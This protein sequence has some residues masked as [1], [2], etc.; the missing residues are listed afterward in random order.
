MNHLYNNKGD[1]NTPREKNLI[2]RH[3]TGKATEKEEKEL[4]D[5]IEEREENK[6]FFLQTKS[7]WQTTGSAKIDF[8]PDKEWKKIHKR[9]NKSEPSFPRSFWIRF[10]KTA[11]VFIFAFTIGWILKTHLTQNTGRTWLQVQVPAGQITKVVLSDG[12]KVW[13]DS[14][15]TFRYPSDFSQNGRNVIL[16]GQAYFEVAENRNSP[17]T[18][19]TDLMDVKVLGTRFSLSAYK[20]DRQVRATLLDGEIVLK[21]KISESKESILYPGDQARYDKKTNELKIQHLPDKEQG[22]IGWLNGRYEFFDEPLYHILNVASRWYNVDFIIND[23]SLKNNRFT[24][25]MKRDYPVDQLLKLIQKTSDV[26]IEKNDKT[27]NLKPKK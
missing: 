2:V 7:V 10:A 20:E 18:V 4:L 25:V 5:W 27:I 22:E 12:S 13:I 14:E 19:S 1:N 6:N 9:I 21:N 24:G 15:T 17:F 16:D 26:I 8:S 3:L 23:D 11:A